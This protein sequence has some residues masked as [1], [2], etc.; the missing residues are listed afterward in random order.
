MDGVT[1]LIAGLLTALHRS[2]APDVCPGGWPWAVSLL[3]V[4][5][6]LLPAVGALLVAM[7]RKAVGNS[8]SVMCAA[9]GFVFA[10]LAPLIVFTVTG[11]HLRR[12]RR[13]A[14]PYPGS[15]GR[16]CASDACF[17]V[18]GSQ[19]DYLGRGTVGQSFMGTSPLRL[20]VGLVALGLVPV[21]VA[22]FTFVQAR[23]ALRRGPRWP[24]VFFW[25]STLG[26]GRADHGG[27]RAH[28]RP[29]VARRR[30]SARCSACCCRWRSGRRRGRWSAASRRSPGAEGG[31]GRTRRHRPCAR[32]PAARTPPGSHPSPRRRPRAATGPLVAAASRARRAARGS[33][34]SAGWA[35][36]GSAGCG[37]PR[38]TSSGT[39][40][41]S[42]RRTRPTRRPRS[43]SS[44]RPVRWPPC[45][46][47]TAC[48]S[49]TWCPRAATPACP[50]W[51]A[52]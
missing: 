18:L 41:R 12:P 33:G 48:G 4:L 21:I 16:A 10:G 17:A 15:T 30:V 11:P 32:P 38:T 27:A 49:T 1:A 31:A 34:R 20:G 22:T 29:P 26:R 8:A 46:T 13:R 7:L 28:R 52:W 42:R 40:S 35:P 44:A 19:A 50:T 6:G 23:I 2:V 37:S 25:L 5:V 9:I 3:G 36:A 43:A 39:S 51:T 24:A 47:R 45:G 14:P